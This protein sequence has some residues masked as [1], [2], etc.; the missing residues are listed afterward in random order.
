MRT[1]KAP[2]LAL[3]ALLLLSGITVLANDSFA[4]PVEMVNTQYTTFVSSKI[5]SES[6]DIFETTRTHSSST[7]INDSIHGEVVYGS[8]TFT[9]DAGADAGLF[10]VSAYGSTKMLAQ[11]ASARSELTFSPV[12]NGSQNIAIDFVGDYEWYFSDGLVSLFDLT[13][14]QEIWNYSWSLMGQGTVPW[15]SAG[16]D[17]NATAALSLDTFLA[18]DHT[19]NLTMSTGIYSNGDAELIN[20]RLSGLETVPVPEPATILLFGIGMIGLVC[21]FYRAGSRMS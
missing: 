13:L 15:L 20:M 17:P 9:G 8:R 11:Q 1:S 21:S 5:W 12:F 4:L 3:A 16:G 6:G 7:P 18:D 2:L 19:Y 10:E 14:N